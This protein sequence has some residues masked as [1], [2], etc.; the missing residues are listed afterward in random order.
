MLAITALYAGLLS[1]LFLL[2]SAVVI[3]RRGTAK[4]GLGDGGNVSLERAIR[5]HGNF[6]E[7]APLILILI[8]IMELNQVPIWQ[9]HLVGAMALLG[10]LLHGYC[11]A[12]TDSLPLART[13]GMVLT[14]T[15]LGIGALG[16]LW[17]A[18]M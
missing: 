10:R 3:R 14:L 6:A 7:Y 12:F 9:L 2:L 13:G 11:F 5:G 1:L 16:C 4:V 18:I 15:A 8:A 17:S